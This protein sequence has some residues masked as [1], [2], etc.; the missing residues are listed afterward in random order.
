MS[1]VEFSDPS[2]AR[3]LLAKIAATAASLGQVR[4]MEVCGTHTMEIGRLGLRSLLPKNVEL[5]SGPGCPVCVTP[6]SYI[7]AAADLALKKNARLATFGDMVRVPGDRTSLDEARAK[8]AVVDVVTSP[9]N[10]LEIASQNKKDQVVFLAVGFETTAPATARAIEIAK[11]EKLKNISFFASHKIVPPA[12]SAL[13][14]DKENALS[15]FLLPGHVSAIIGEKPYQPLASAGLPAV[16]TGFE[17]LDILS[18]IMMVCDMIANKK[19]A[20]LNAYQRI[21]HKQGNPKAVAAV[22]KVFDVAD[23]AWRGLGMLPQSGLAIK[24]DYQDFDAAARF[25]VP[26]DATAAMPKACSCGDVIRGRMRPD[27][28]PL[29]TVSC[30]PENPVGPCMVSSEGSCAAYFKYGA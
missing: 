26:A 7:D 25:S 3:L 8:G 14:S 5:I 19:A 11:Q 21:V 23:T 29:F 13:I 22:N 30:T 1:L 6:G 4:I 16:I 15:G 2:T 9:L 18:G 10:A 27:Q 20:V 24:K 12:L 17:P 28:C